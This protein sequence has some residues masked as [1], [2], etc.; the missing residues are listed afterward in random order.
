VGADVVTSGGR[1]RVLAQEILAGHLLVQTEDMRRVLIEASDVL[2]VISSG[3]SGARP[4][5]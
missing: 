1:A 2:S 3:G 4:N 5:P